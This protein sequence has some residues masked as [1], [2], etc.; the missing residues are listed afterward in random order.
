MS[1][2]LLILAF[3]LMA[4][5]YAGAETGAYRLNRIRL[6]QRAQAGSRLARLQQHLLADTQ[7]FVCMTLAGHNG[8]VY[9]ATLLC[10]ALLSAHF[11][12]HLTAE[13]ASTVILAPGL[14]LVAEVLPKSLFQ[15]LPNRLLRWSSP[16]LLVSY[17]A[18]WPVTKLLLGVVVLWRG[19]LGGRVAA[20]QT[21]VTSQYLGFFLTE[22]KQEGVITPQQD[23]M[24]RNLMQ[25]ATRPVQRAMIPLARVRMISLDATGSEV[26][27]LTAEHDHARLP[28]YEGSRSNVVGILLGLDHLCNSGGGDI[29]Q[30]FRKPTFLKANLPLSDAFRLLQKAGQTMAVVVDARDRAIG[31]VTMGDLLQEI[32]ST[33]EAA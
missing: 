8:A 22:G 6:R 25:L 16:M 23:L 20:R 21:V 19:L 24:V 10:T 2:V 11:E 15:V 5:F 13:L 18:L 7:A 29:R 12:S 32:F 3:A 1:S 28:V 17:V 30:L 27:Q 31:I 26:E 9:A 4:G 14:L 33:L